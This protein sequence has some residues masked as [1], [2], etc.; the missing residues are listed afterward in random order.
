MELWAIETTLIRLMAVIF[1][2][3]LV[4]GGSERGRSAI[5][6]FALLTA[7]FLSV[8]FIR[9]GA[10]GLAFS[11]AG[12]APAPLLAAPFVL[13]GRIA[14]HAVAAAA[15]AGA[16]LGPA[17]LLAAGCVTVLLF[18]IDRFRT[19]GCDACPDRFDRPQA[20][21]GGAGAEMPFETPARPRPWQ[22]GDPLAPGR[23]EPA[24]VAARAIP[25]RIQFAVATLAAL[26][27]DLFV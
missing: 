4:H 27:T 12:A 2:L 15:A 8:N 13:R 23:P 6:L 7:A 24:P 20:T 9:G 11:L 10:L 17:G 25:L 18:G 19:A 1:V 22:I 3:A 21:A 5:A 14:P 16:V 26:M